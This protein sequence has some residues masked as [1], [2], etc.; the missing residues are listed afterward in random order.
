MYVGFLGQLFLN[1]LKCVIIPLVIPSLITAIG[2]I[3]EPHKLL[4]I[5]IDFPRINE[6]VPNWQDRSPYHGL[7]SVHH[8]V[9]R[10][11]GHRPGGH[12]PARGARK[13]GRHREN[14]GSRPGQ[15]EERDHG[16]HPDGPPEEQLPSQHRPGHHPAV[17]NAHHLPWRGNRKYIIR[18]SVENLHCTSLGYGF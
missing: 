1:M 9:G 5:I 15:E 4:R 8:R 3:F 17:Q 2:K 16:G 12:H 10:H 6:S 14:R 18:E 11:P 7:L 13:L